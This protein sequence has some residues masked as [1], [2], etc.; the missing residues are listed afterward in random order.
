MT[1]NKVV[2]RCDF[3]D[4]YAQ[5]IQLYAIIRSYDLGCFYVVAVT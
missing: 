2:T 5:F 4:G 1:A 3:Y